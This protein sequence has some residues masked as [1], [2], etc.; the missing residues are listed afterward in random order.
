[1]EIALLNEHPIATVLEPL[2]QFTKANYI[3]MLMDVDA[4]CQLNMKKVIFKK[5]SE[6]ISHF[7]GATNSPVLDL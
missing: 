5:I 6:Y 1:M 3:V 7:R 4:I 2:L